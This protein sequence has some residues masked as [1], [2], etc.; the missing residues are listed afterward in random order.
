MTQSVE[1]VIENLCD[2]ERIVSSSLHGLIMATAYG[3]PCR[4]AELSDNVIG[5]GTKFRDFFQSVH[6]SDQQPLNMRGCLPLAAAL[7]EEVPPYD[8]VVDTDA[9]WAA[10]PFR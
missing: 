8:A 3:I 10:C 7:C 1:A 5:D 2:C 6:M 4:W 9:L